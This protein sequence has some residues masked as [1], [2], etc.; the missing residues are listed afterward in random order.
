MKHTLNKDV[1]RLCDSAR[2]VLQHLIGVIRHKCLKHQRE[3]RRLS[4]VVTPRSQS[5]NCGKRNS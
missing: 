4:N 5:S 3:F 2:Q 1:Q